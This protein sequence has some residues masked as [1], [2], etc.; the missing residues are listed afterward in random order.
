MLG[1]SKSKS[2]R[3]ARLVILVAATLVFLIASHPARVP[4]LMLVLPFMLL[5]VTLF[6][7]ILELI[8]LFQPAPSEGGQP[9]AVHHPYLLAALLAGFPVLLLVLQSI[10]QLNR[11]DVLIAFAIFLLAY[12][13]IARGNI[14]TLRR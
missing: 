5:F 1:Y 14:P 9:A 7:A 4:A 3:L 13:F 10:M 8:N 12:V 11:W 2:F 6:Y